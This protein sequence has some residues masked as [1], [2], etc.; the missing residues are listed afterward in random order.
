MQ[1]KQ[2]N[3]NRYASC[4][5]LIVK[6]HSPNPPHKKM[7]NSVDSEL[8]FDRYIGHVFLSPSN[9]LERDTLH[10]STKIRSDNCET[11]F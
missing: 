1:N 5:K 7:Y 2:T 6:Y 4:L 11:L 10:L 3:K 8:H 9:S